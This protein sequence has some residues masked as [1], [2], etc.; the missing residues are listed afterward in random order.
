MASTYSTNLGIEL[1]GSGEQSGTWGT[2]TNNN[3]GTLLEQAISGVTTTACTGGTDTITI[4]NGASGTARNMFLELTGTGGGSLVVPANKKLYFIYNNTSLAITV[5]VTGQTGV[6]VP[7]AAKTIL[8]MNSAGTDV[9]NATNYFSAL[10][11]GAALPVASGGTGLA[12]LTANNVILGNGVASPTFVAPTTNGNILTANGTTWVSSAPATNGT[13]TSV[14]VS[15]GTT[16]LTTSGGPI[17]T[18][19]TITLAGTLAVANGGTGVTST[20][21]YAV[22]T[23]NSAGT[24]FAGIAN[25]TT[26]QVLTATTSGAPSWAAPAT[27]GTVTSVAA[28]TLGTTGTDL[29]STVANGT[30]TPV[31]TLQVP[32]ASASNR[33]ALSAADW[34]TFNNKLTSGGALGTPS[35]GTVTNLTGTASININGTVGATTKNTGQFTQITAINPN[36]V[37]S[38]CA[39][40]SGGRGWSIQSTDFNGTTI[41]SALQFGL[42]SQTG[43]SFASIN[44]YTSGGTNLSQITINS[45]HTFTSTGFSTGTLTTTGA[46]NY[47][48]VTLSNSVTG[49]GSMVLSTSPTLTTPALG[50]PSSGTLTNATGLPLTTGVTGTLP[51]ANG[52]TGAATAIAYAVQCGGTTSTDAHQSVASV[53]T[54][55]QVLTSNGAGA[56]PT[57][58]TA[59]G[60]QLSYA[61]F[62]T[63]G[64]ATWTC[65][66]GVTKVL[67]IVIGGGAG[68]GGAGGGA[69]HAGGIAIGA[70]T[71]VPGT[72]YSYTVGGGSA[73][74][75]GTAGNGGTSSFASFCSATGGGNNAGAVGVGSSGTFSNWHVSDYLENGSLE[76]AECAG[77]VFVGSNVGKSG[78]SSAYAATHGNIPGAAGINTGTYGGGGVVYLQYVG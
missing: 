29:S 74:T 3:L 73:G 2:T 40:D 46:L 55:G 59:A 42:G 13:V 27:N 72:G 68:Y 50:T 44:A 28:I 11:L 53:G 64:T 52:G 33:G 61:F 41:G 18:S 67:A 56:L 35:S 54:S 57:F 5:K 10:T 65:P 51:V 60:G 49:T 31:I 69:G 63:V 77:A 43:N 14:G 25:G 36:G 24:G 39:V 70:Y 76:S 7:A 6:S 23:G 62:N 26:G 9:V 12:T 1:I 30:T 15:G 66:T 48:G 75:S 38:T 37:Y 45:I 58:Q 78:A 17:T 19:G 20:T 32:T 47:G 22:Y 8:V 21:A 16:G 34:T 71:V 4:P